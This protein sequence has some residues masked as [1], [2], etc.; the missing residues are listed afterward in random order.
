MSGRPILELTPAHIRRTFEVNTLSHFW[1]VKALL[2]SMIE[3]KKDAMIVTVASVV[4][5]L[6]LECL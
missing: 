5:S 2:P 3:A 4:R 1:F 6:S